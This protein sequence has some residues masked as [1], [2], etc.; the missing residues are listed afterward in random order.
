MGGG[1]C[2]G[3]NVVGFWTPRLDDRGGAP[4]FYPEVCRVELASTEYL[5]LHAD[6]STIFAIINQSI[7]FTMVTSFNPQSLLALRS[8]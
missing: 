3:G 7:S 2:R 5:T 4:S 1:L 6:S 8:S